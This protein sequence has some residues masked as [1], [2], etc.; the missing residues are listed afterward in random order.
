MN[1]TKSAQEDSPVRIHREL[2]AKMEQAMIDRAAGGPNADPPPGEREVPRAS[3]LAMECARRE[4]YYL[5]G[6]AQDPR[7]AASAAATTAGQALEADVLADLVA[8][9]PGTWQQQ[10]RYVTP[11][12][13]GTADAVLYADESRSQAV[14][15]ADSKT[16][17]VASWEI[18][19]RR[20][21]AEKPSSGSDHVDSQLQLYMHASGAKKAVAVFRKTGGNARD[22]SK[23]VYLPVIYDHDPEAVTR[24]RTIATEAMRGRDRGLAPPR[25]YDAKDWHCTYCSYRDSCWRSRP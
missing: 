1:D 17:N 24:L 21:E 11:W 6:G 13:R 16:A 5:T 10:V 15:V 9:M 2:Q 23:G 14:L 22:M 18:Q 25:A 8:A 3:S 19:Q 7:S 4:F 20:A 12:F